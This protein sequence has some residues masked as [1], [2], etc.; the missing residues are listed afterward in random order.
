M[1]NRKKSYH[2]DVTADTIGFICNFIYGHN[3]QMILRNL[4]S[5]STLFTN[6]C[7]S[8]YNAE[9]LNLV[10][11]QKKN[12]KKTISLMKQKNE[13]KMINDV[14]IIASTKKKSILW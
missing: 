1:T 2:S 6:I 11:Y 10:A 12:I 9:K 3:Y 8:I 4:V 14:T 5:T 7:F 13:K